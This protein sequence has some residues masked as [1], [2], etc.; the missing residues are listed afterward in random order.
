MLKTTFER[1]SYEVVRY[2]KI[3]FNTNLIQSGNLWFLQSV[4]LKNLNAEAP[5]KSVLKG[6]NK[7]HITSR[8][9]TKIWLQSRT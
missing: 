3:E 2:R 7:T 6:K 1:L 4:I 9:R 5:L 8:I